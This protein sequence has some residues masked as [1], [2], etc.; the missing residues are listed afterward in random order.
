MVG[1]G[2]PDGNTGDARATLARKLIDAVQYAVAVTVVA[3]V[4]SAVPSVLL[5]AGLV[6]VKYGL[7]VLGFLAFGYASF[8]LQPVKPWKS[9]GHRRDREAGEPTPFRRFVRRLPPAAWFPI[10]PEERFGREVKL[11]L[12]SVVMLAVSYV[13]EVVFGVG[14]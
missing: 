2:T 3:A 4:V 10:E 5:G 14:V 6:G 9:G 13:M 1:A 8:L 11:L 7:F 12:A